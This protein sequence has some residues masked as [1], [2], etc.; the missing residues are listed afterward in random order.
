[1]PE[2]LAGL[3]FR[4]RRGTL[5][6]APAIAALAIQVFLDTYAPDGVAPEIAREVL[7]GYGEDAFSARLRDGNT[8]WLVAEAP[9]GLIGFAQ[10]TCGRFSPVPSSVGDH[11]LVRLYVQPAVHGQGVGRMLLREA[12]WLAQRAGSPHLWLT[13]WDGNHRAHAFYERAQ[14]RRVGTTEHVIGTSA[15]LNHVFVKSLHDLG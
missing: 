8:S 1:M 12:E 15:Y 7:D 5:A 14:Y 13:A 9:A 6:D 11:E 3:R 2:A 4:C 10:V